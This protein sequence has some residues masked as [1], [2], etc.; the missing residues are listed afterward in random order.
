MELEEKANYIT[1]ED[2]MNQVGVMWMFI[3][4]TMM[5]IISDDQVFQI[6]LVSISFLM[7]VL[8]MGYSQMLRRRRRQATG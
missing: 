3:M 5:A 8:Y 6:I 2:F 4:L 7:F 1:K